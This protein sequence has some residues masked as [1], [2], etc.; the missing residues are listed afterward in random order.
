MTSMP[1]VK[2]GTKGPIRRLVLLPYP[3]IAQT[4]AELDGGRPLRG[5][6]LSERHIWQHAWGAHSQPPL[7]TAVA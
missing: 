5:R 1:W 6:G 4:R 2:K 7:T 3:P